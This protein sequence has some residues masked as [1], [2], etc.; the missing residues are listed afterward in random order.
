LEKIMKVFTQHDVAVGTCSH[1]E[2]GEAW[3]DRYSIDDHFKGLCTLDQVGSAKPIA[4]PIEDEVLDTNIEGPSS[5]WMR[6]AFHGMG[7]KKAFVQF[8]KAN[9]A[10]MWP[11]LVKNG[12]AQLLKEEPPP[13]KLEEYSNA[14]LE[15]LSSNDIKRL[16][17]GK[18]QTE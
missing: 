9:P 16:L 13:K 7:G 4:P 1:E 18:K 3:E 6:A 17:L 12:L 8:C 10:L 15:A 11:Q 5:D 14:E 2:V